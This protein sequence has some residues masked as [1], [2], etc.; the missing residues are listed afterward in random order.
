[1]KSKEAGIQDGFSLH[2]EKRT[3]INLLLEFKLQAEG[4][5]SMTTETIED[6]MVEK[7][8]WKKTTINFA[9]YFLRINAWNMK[10]IWE[11]RVYWFFLELLT[12]FFYLHWGLLTFTCTISHEEA[13][14]Q[15]TAMSN[16]PRTQFDCCKRTWWDDFVTEGSAFRSMG[17]L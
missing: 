6:N 15:S 9:E 7:K 13:V 16:P 2:T 11:I 4:S 12:G 14:A 17:P 5:L 3:A 8:K 10:Y 1:M